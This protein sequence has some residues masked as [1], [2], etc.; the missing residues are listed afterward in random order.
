MDEINEEI[1]PQEGNNGESIRPIFIEDEMT[2]SYI[3]YAM[4]VIIGRALPDVRDGLKPV[5]RRILYA[6]AELG[7][8]SNRAYKKSARIVGEVLGKYHPHGDTAVY[9]AIVRMAQD[10]N[11]RY[12]LVDGHGNFGSIDGDSAAAQRYTEAR[13][14][15]VAE[16]LL[17]DLDKDTVGFLPN[18]D[19]TL[20]EPFPLPARIPNLLVN[21]SSGI[22]VGMATNIP[23]HNMGEVVDSLVHLI[24]YPE[25]TTSDL[26][27]F[28]PGPDFPTGANIINRGGMPQ[29][30]ETG[31]GPVIMRGIV[32][33]VID[34]K[35]NKHRLIIRELPYQ[36]N[37]ARLIEGIVGLVKDNKITG[38]SD[39]RDESNREGIRVVIELKRDEE[40][41]WVLNQLYKHTPLQTSFG[42]IMLAIVEGQPKVM[43]LK[44]V[45]SHY[46]D[47]RYEVVR[48]R[49]EFELRKAEE[50][51][52]I[53][54]GL[55]IA[56][57]NI[58][59]IIQ[60]IREAA[61]PVE[62]KEALMNG[63]DLSERQAQAILDM[64]LQ[65]LTGLERDKIETEYQEL[66]VKIG[67]YKAI[68]ADSAKIFD[69]IKTELLTVKD[70]F[71]DK[72]RSVFLDSVEEITKEDLVKDEDVVITITHQGYIKRIPL[73]TYQAQHRG[74]KGKKSGNVID[75]DF[76][77]HIYVAN[78][79]D[80]FLFFT[81]F[82]KVHCLKVWEIPEGSRQAKGRAVINFI[83]L[84]TVAGEQ[85]AAVIPVKEFSSDVFI[86]LCTAQGQ[87]KK[88]ALDQ[89][90]FSVSRAIIGINLTGD[91]KLV[92]I[93][94]CDGQS[95]IMITTRQGKAIRFKEDEVRA[96][97]RATQGVRAINLE[98]EDRVM[99][100]A[101]VPPAGSPEE[102]TLSLLTVTENG[103][104]KRTTLA[105]YPT[106]H[107]GGKGVI[108]FK[109]TD[110]NGPSV[111]SMSVSLEDEV[112]IVTRMGMLIRT[113][114]ASVTPSG[115][116]T[117][118]KILIRMKK[119]DQV[120]D[121]SPIIRDEEE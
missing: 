32:D 65:R 99:D 73:E 12:L 120:I 20:K 14:T 114:V 58:D 64:R 92:G 60:V 108:N 98:K 38:I 100:M 57:E 110:V 90:S 89:Y 102:K 13:L 80:Y 52:H 115:R 81:S 86:T 5:H 111:V 4:S 21:G 7:N 27:N 11:Q 50:R 82:G 121:V 83:K 48:R 26:M 93:G 119:E 71:N 46:R 37:K 106:I 69:I 2:N 78:S 109:Q 23:P 66:L 34:E 41:E 76:V 31:R 45:L 6:M 77:R 113:S 79:K 85:V 16:E 17:E 39:I 68:L 19:E 40:P 101:I 63:F 3:D 29:I 44:E 9:D 33:T 107:R 35:R 36:V 118:G 87:I 56:L 105:Q 75:E 84:D 47:H 72:R 30:Y 51:A 74:G 55:R 42:V 104:G 59:V 54:E 91:D 18:Y 116:A 97:G 61:N 94:L 96:T 88:T 117:I 15:R 22:A 25:C 95:E 43:G 112:V 28:V 67:E 70:K 1:T 53:L 10:F 49:T 8:W 62:A 103:Y 24:D